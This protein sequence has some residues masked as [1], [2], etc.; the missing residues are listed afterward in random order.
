MTDP[1]PAE[2]PNLISIGTQAM[3]QN[4]KRLGI[5]WGLRPATVRVVNANAT[6]SAQYDG[7]EVPIDMI[8]MMGPLTIGERVYAISVPPSG[9]YIVGAAA[10]RHGVH[11]GETGSFVFTFVTQ[12][13]VTQ[14]IVFDRP[15]QETPVVL[16]NIN[17]GSGP[18]TNWQSRAFNISTTGFTLWVSTAGA[19]T[20]W[21]NVA[22][23]WAAYTRLTP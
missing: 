11:T 16:T 22:V 15:F 13:S 1:T 14:A 3:V 20:S 18:T 2:A 5:T 7:D 12:T 4:A 8:S 23:Q 17:S 19:A 10:Q 6:I 21:T 9:N